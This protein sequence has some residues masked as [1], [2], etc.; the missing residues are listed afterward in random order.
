VT[1][2]RQDGD[3]LDDLIPLPLGRTARRIAAAVLTG[4]AL[5]LVSWWNYLLFHALAETFSVVVAFSVFMIGWSSRKYLENAYLL[6]VAVAYLFLGFLDLLHTL[7]YVG[8]SVFAEQTFQA[9]QL[10]TAARYLEALTLLAAF[11]VLRVRRT[12]SL[13]LLLTVYGAITAV[14]VASIFRWR[15]FP[16]CFVAGQG[17]TTFKIASE[18]VII[19]LYA[20]SLWLLRANRARFE[21]AV[22]RPLAASILFAIA[23]EFCFT[24]Y[25]SNYGLANFV[26]H[27]FKI[28]S[29]SAVYVALI[30]TGVARP[31]AL[32]FRELTIANA[33]LTEEIEA[34]KRTELAKDAAIRDLHAALDEVRKLRGIIPICA[35]CKKIR[36]DRGAWNQLEAYIQRHSEAQF[37]HGICP[38]CMERHFPEL[39]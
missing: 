4:V 12:P 38:D 11:A 18:Y 39:K 35:H 13:L 1:H 28:L 9:N 24:L 21:P 30:D 14:L 15:I 27:L 22:W 10:W 3:R 34:R 7:S 37:S 20:A 31:Y 2:A 17:Q 36:D 6:F 26:G 33:R 25:A 16:A 23:S 8:M 32:V 19:A 29:Y 5:L